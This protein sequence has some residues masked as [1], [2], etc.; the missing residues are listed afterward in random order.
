MN[1]RQECL[2]PTIRRYSARTATPPSTGSACSR[3]SSCTSALSASHLPCGSS[4]GPRHHQRAEARGHQL[5]RLVGR[6]KDLLGDLVLELELDTG[7][8]EQVLAVLAGPP[9]G[10]GNKTLGLRRHV[11]GDGLKEGS[12]LALR[13]PAAEAEA[14]ARAQ[15]PGRLSRSHLVTR[16]EH[17]PEGRQHDIEALVVERQ[18][19][20]VRLDP[21]NLDPGRL[22]IRPPRDE[23]LRGQI[24]RDDVGAAQSSGNRGVARA[25]G[26]VEYPLARLHVD[27]LDQR[28]ADR[29]DQLRD[30]VEIAGSPGL[31]GALLE[32]RCGC[33]VHCPMTSDGAVG[34]DMA[35]TASHPSYFRNLRSS[36]GGS[37]TKA[38][39]RRMYS[40]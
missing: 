23:Q 21:F 24:G 4:S 19:L 8:R 13:T 3:Y 32:L 7:A 39:V 36:T 20:G 40:S 11:P 29:Q 16:R 28:P 12:D 14:A 15:H 25:S 6:G 33:F 17:D 1:G 5:E 26:D 18:R 27:A 9:G 2:V 22:R 31:L 37:G 30:V 35:F 38:L 34:C 10:R